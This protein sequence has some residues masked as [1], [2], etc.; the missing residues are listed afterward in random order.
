MRIFKKLSRALGS[1]LCRFGEEI[2]SIT[3][4]Y[5]D[6][7]PKDVEQCWAVNPY[8]MTSMERRF[9]LLEAV[10][11]IVKNNIRGAIVE[12]GVWKGGSMMLVAQSLLELGVTDRHLYLFDTFEGMPP[13][14]SSDVSRTGSSALDVLTSELNIKQDSYVWA[15][16]GLEEVQSNLASSSYPK[17][18]VNFVKGKVEDTL[19]GHAPSEI[20]LL[21]L[22]TDWYASTKHELEHLYSR[23]APNG[24]MIIDDYGFWKGARQAVDEFLATLP[25]RPYLHRVDH[26]ARLIIK[27]N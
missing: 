16:A 23:L 6:M 8:S 22:D 27:P 10:R 5:P 11:Y 26:D 20:A 18:R 21:R 15:L 9:A 1:R 3:M 7:E 19:P 12:C 25:H 24:I 2:P 17:E 4:R 13:P 14:S